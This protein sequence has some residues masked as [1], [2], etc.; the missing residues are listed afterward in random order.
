MTLV[1]DESFIDFAPTAQPS[2]PLLASYPNQLVIHTMT[3]SNANNRLRLAYMLS[4]ERLKDRIK[5]ITHPWN[6]NALAIE[7]GKFLLHNG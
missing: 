4:N 2:E 3:K 7:I 6:V 5:R 1:L